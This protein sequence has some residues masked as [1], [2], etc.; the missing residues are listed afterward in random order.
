MA[1]YD[2]IVVGAGP[3]GSTAAMTAAEAGLN[4]LLLE[5]SKHPG[6]KNVSGFGLTS[7]AYRDFP[8]L[9]GMELPSMRIGRK[10]VGH[11]LSPPPELDERICILS[12][13]SKRISYPEGR[14]FITVM[15]MRRE[16]DQYLAE[17][18]VASGAKLTTA[19]LVTGL[20]KE[21]GVVKGVRLEGGEEY[22][23]S[24]VI[25]ADGVLSPTAR[26]A[27]IRTR[28]RPDE[29]V[30]VC[31][32][33][34]RASKERID[35][36]ADDATFHG[37]F[38][39][40][41]GGNYLM[42]MRESVHLGGPGVGNSLVSR[43]VERRVK[44]AKELLDTIRAPAT[45]NILKAVDAVPRE[46]QAHC[47]PWMD[48]MP[49]RIFTGGMMLVGDAA[50]LPEPLWA[51][52]VWQAMY[53]GRLAAE[54]AAE[55]IAEKD[56]SY[57]SMERYYRRLS[58]SPVGRDFIGG[59]QLRRLFEMLGDPELLGDLTEMAAD[60]MINMFM[61]GQEVHAEAMSRIFSIIA[62]NASALSGVARLYAPILAK[63][64]AQAAK[65]RVKAVKVVGSLL[66]ALNRG[67]SNERRR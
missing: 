25:G 40:G 44:P 42:F 24:V 29:V 64:T 39:P 66:S 27:G 48:R 34:Y 58:D 6:E 57:Y 5:R 38:G 18:A 26:Y 4:T 7:K 35:W 37:F 11:M 23:A 30:S 19:S 65:D 33:D 43:L 41:I 1:K 49:E 56:T 36:V 51:E 12:G 14:E 10:C 8:W 47:L 20:V 13:P 61:N 17:R 32:I 3:G 21:G 31:C 59:V 67:G 60:I 55:V 16:F 9:A 45:R 50:G 62:E 22:R 15:I 63:V 52:G 53:S 46:W 54:V 2:V 28:W